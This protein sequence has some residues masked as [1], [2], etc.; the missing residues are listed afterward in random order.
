MEKCNCKCK[1]CDCKKQNSNSAFGILLVVVGSVVLALN[2][3][4]KGA[5]LRPILFSWQMLLFLFGLFFAVK[6]QVLKGLFIM[7]VAAFFVMP[8]LAKVFPE[9]LSWVQP[10]FLKTYWALLLVV[11]GVFII[12]LRNFCKKDCCHSGSFGKYDGFGQSTLENA[13]GFLFREVLFSGIDEIFSE[14]IFKGG[15]FKCTFGGINLDLRQTELSDGDT[16]VRIKCTCGGVVLLVPDSW[17]VEIRISN[18]FGGTTDSRLKNSAA[19]K[20]KKLIITG[21]CLFGGC[22]IK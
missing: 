12:I 9:T 14:P 11:A 16:I 22:E 21:D 15:D 5:D 19:D 10:D 7:L 18:I 2:F 3:S 1:K 4:A 13:D 8:P 20:S 17:H 6:R